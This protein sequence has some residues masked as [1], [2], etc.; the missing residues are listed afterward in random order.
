MDDLRA[1]R[2]GAHRDG[3]ERVAPEQNAAQ[4][5]LNISGRLGAAL[6][7]GVLVQNFDPVRHD[8]VACVADVSSDCF[9]A[10]DRGT[11]R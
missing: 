1:R 9:A 11:S 5:T 3:Y 10:F 7:A 8:S 2:Q 4:N 6:V